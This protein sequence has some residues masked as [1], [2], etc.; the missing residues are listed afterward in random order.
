MV[1]AV[2]T[3]TGRWSEFTDCVRM[4]KTIPRMARAC[5]AMEPAF[6]FVMIM[7]LLVDM[8]RHAA[9]QGQGEDK[10]KD[11]DKDNE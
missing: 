8:D 5:R 3:A 2:D 7:V 11:N 6:C 4:P 10:D 9:S 1:I